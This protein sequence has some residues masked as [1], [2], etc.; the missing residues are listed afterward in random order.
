MTS[1]RIRLMGGI[2]IYMENQRLDLVLSH[3]AISIIALLLISDNKR[4]NKQ[5]LAT[6]LWPDS[7]DEASRYNLR[8]NLWNIKK[9]V[10]PKEEE[11][12][13]CKDKNDV[14]INPD[15]KYYSDIG[16]IK[17]YNKDKQHSKE[18]LETIKSLFKGDFLE[19]VI[20]K[21]SQ[22]ISDLTLMERMYC[23][24]IHADVLQQLYQE[25]KKND[26]NASCIYNLFEMLLIDPFN[27][28]TAC[29]I[30]KHMKKQSQPG[31]AVAFY[32]D[33]SANLRRDLNVSPSPE[34]RQFYEELT[35]TSASTDQKP[36]EKDKN[37][38]IVLNTF[39]MEEIDYFWMSECI[40]QI[41][42]VIEDEVIGEIS[43]IL[44]SHLLYITPGIHARFEDRV[45]VSD[46]MPKN[47]LP[48]QLMNSFYEFIKIVCRFNIL[49][50]IVTDYNLLDVPSK[51]VLALIEKRPIQGLDVIKQ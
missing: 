33:F 8:Y 4:M 35:V 45:H 46:G 28:K 44:L 1:L 24:N 51:S 26:D 21:G 42:E 20:F 17:E 34:L 10:P 25:N 38:P 30:M 3:K 9:L 6:L 27:E 15:F 48:I 49:T 7:D 19:G 22:E 23:Q 31:K 37:N 40:N 50:I 13:I 16:V 36:V 43:D 41:F 29:N 14:Y 39:C 47:I 32:K 5:R 18:E 12:F 2:S 11:D